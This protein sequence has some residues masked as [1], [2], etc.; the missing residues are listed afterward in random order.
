MK[1]LLQFLQWM[2]VGLT[3]LI[4]LALTF[5]TSINVVNGLM[6][7]GAIAIVIPNLERK[8]FQGNLMLL[9]SSIIR[10]GAWYV[11]LLMAVFLAQFP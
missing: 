11:L 7:L 1:A 4:L 8:L 2:L 5:R 3:G 6:L 9:H 10:L